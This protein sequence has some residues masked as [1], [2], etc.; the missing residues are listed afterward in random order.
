MIYSI[1]EKVEKSIRKSLRKVTQSSSVS[2]IKESG[3]PVAPGNHL[4]FH[5]RR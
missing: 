2:L 3:V 4:G 1:K 5:P